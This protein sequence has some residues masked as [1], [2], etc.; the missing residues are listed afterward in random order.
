M[1][2]LVVATLSAC[3]DSSDDSDASPADSPTVPD[4]SSPMTT[5]TPPPEPREL[6]LLPPNPMALTREADLVPLKAEVL[7]FHVHA[8]LDVFVDGQPIVVPAGIGIDI[9]DPAVHKFRNPIGYGGIDPA[10]EHVCIS[11]LH[12][13]DSDGVLHT[14]SASSTPN[15]LGQ[16]FTEWGVRLTPTCVGEFCESDTSIAFFVDGEPYP[17][18]PGRI[19]LADG[20]EIAIV[21]GMPPEEVPSLFTG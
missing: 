18:D 6:W 1:V 11:P 9:H 2:A 16:F 7:R 15:N 10:C 19:E 3:S 4:T 21:I 12:T 20:R 17:G 5:T 14:E 13:H 8:H